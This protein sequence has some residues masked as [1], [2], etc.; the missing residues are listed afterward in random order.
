MPPAPVQVPEHGQCDLPHLLL[1]QVDHAVGLGALAEQRL[2]EQLVQLLA[3]LGLP[4]HVDKEAVLELRGH[5]FAEGGGVAG[6]PVLI[7][8]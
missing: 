8:L 1:E 4:A 6:L 5:L 2:L 3:A 7:V